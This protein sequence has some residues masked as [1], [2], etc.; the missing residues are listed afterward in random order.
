MRRRT[1][2]GILSLTL[3]LGSLA[4]AVFSQE[5]VQENAQEPPARREIAIT[6]DD[7]PF[8]GPDLGLPRVRAA[9]AAILAAL[10][11]EGVPA[12]GFVNEG[13]LY[14]AGE[15][16]ARTALL[17]E[18][19]EAGEEL[20][21]HTFSHLSLQET[22]L[23]AFEEDVVRGETVTRWLL[24]RRGKTLRYFRHPFLRT[25]PTLETRKDFEGFLAARGYTVA[26]VTIEN[27]D[28]VFSRVYSEAKTKGDAEGMRQTAEAYLRF[29]G[30]QL[31]FWEGVARTVLGRPVRHVLLL[32]DDEINADHL[33]EVL[34]LLKRRGYR[35]VPLEEALRD[36]AYRSP[37]T[38]AGQ[39]G[40]SWLYRWAVSRGVKVDWRREPDPPAPIQRLYDR[41]AQPP[42]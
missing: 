10:R 8:G 20:G 25:G 3:T 12:V 41:L 16:D 36:E 30:A 31:D 35:F 21:N 17:E 40:V 13:R 23:P 7:L 39:A 4:L 24:G 32:H 27:S 19:L 42:G 38:Y 1:I 11:R 14:V 5:P 22:P 37:D 2:L 18:W 29:T 34:A 6:I 28:Y 9:N 26:P 33:G 15:I